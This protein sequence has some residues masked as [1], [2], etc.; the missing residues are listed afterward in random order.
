MR[1]QNAGALLGARVRRVH[2]QVIENAFV[3]LLCLESRHP[4]DPVAALALARCRDF[5]IAVHAD[6]EHR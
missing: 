4:R 6:P 3:D 1:H 5:R 2:D